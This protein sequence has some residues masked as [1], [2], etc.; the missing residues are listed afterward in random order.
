MGRGSDP[1]RVLWIDVTRGLCMIL[2]VMMHVDELHFSHLL[3][4][5]RVAHVWDALTSFTRPARMPTFFYL[6]GLLA[7]RAVYRSWEDAAPKR[8]Y[9]TVYLFVVWSLIYETSRVLLI[10][11]T[12]AA[13]EAVWFGENMLFPRTPLWFV[14]GLIIFF[15]VARFARN[16]PLWLSLGVAAIISAAS[17]SFGHEPANYLGRCLL[18]YLLGCYYPNLA[19]AIH[20][21]ASVVSAGAL[22]LLFAISTASILVI[23]KTTFGAWL[24][25]SFAGMG[26][27]IAACS[28]FEGSQLGDLLAYIGQ[29]TLPIFLLHP[30]LLSWWQHFASGPGQPIFQA[31][32]RHTALAVIYPAVVNVCVVVAALAIYRAAG[33]LR[34]NVLF[35]MPRE[36]KPTRA[37][38]PT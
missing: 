25:A 7:S 31:V 11:P 18:F 24:P 13:G 8:V 9:P 26:F 35:E 3:V 10:G 17:E 6:S 15:L 2:V 14:F 29:R 5:P 33:L 28:L 12:N 22:G 32:L 1:Q 16:L 37:A 38:L 20:R 30:L 23:G 19:V 4:N 36:R 27:C 21:K 34:L